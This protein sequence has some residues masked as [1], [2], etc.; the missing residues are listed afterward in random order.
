MSV[1]IPRVGQ[2]GQAAI[3]P[4][5]SETDAI[6]ATFGR[7]LKSQRTSAGLTQEALAHRCF[8]RTDQVSRFERGRSEPHLTVLLALAQG[9]NTTA[10]ELV[11]TL[12]APTRGA[13]QRKMLT[14]IAADD[15][16][17]TVELASVLELPQ[18]YINQN[19]RCMQSRGWIRWER[20]G[21]H[22]RSASE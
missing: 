22:A 2:T 20:S 7:T 15:G 3:G 13:S 17:S 18:W 8:L 4:D 1:S 21:W 11:A 14:S 9:L 19:A 6:L 10:G 5:I 12:T 16:I